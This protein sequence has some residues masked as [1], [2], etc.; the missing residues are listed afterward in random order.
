MSKQGEYTITIKTGDRKLA[1]TD[2]N[3]TIILHDGRGNKTDNHSLDNLFVNDFEMGSINKFQFNDK[4]L[5]DIDWLEIWRDEFGIA[6]GWFLNTV[7]VEIP[8]SKKQYVFPF[9]K[10]I[11]SNYKYKVRHLDTSLPQHDAN[12]EQRQ[13]EL[14]DNKCLF[15][16]HVKLPGLVAQVILKCRNQRV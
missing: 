9:F 11:K 13:M 4:S 7:E 15:E 5:E 3:V 12:K 10:W 16:L 6:S 14:E 8:Y 2:A 1:G